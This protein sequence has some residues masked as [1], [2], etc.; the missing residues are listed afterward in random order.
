MTSQ[1]SYQF[2]RLATKPKAQLSYSFLPSNSTT[3]RQS[4]LLVFVNGLG[5][6]QVSW[7]GVIHKLRELRPQSYPA[8]LT[9]DRFGQGQTEDRDP[10][11]E[12]AEDPSHA[13]DC[14]AA[15]ADLRQLLKQI[16]ADNLGISDVDSL[17][18]V[19]VANSIG[20]A[21]AR[22]YAQE[23]KATV[24]GLVLLDSVLANS[25]FVSIIPDPDSP[26][27]DNSEPLP[28]GIT[29]DVLREARAVLR[30]TFHPNNGSREGLSRKNLKDLLPHADEPKLDGVKGKGA[31]VTVL[32]HDFEVF[33]NGSVA[34][35][36]PKAASI[37]YANPYWHRYNE[38]L[39]KLTDAGRSK[40]P[41]QVPGADH[42]IQ[43]DNPDF[44]A[45]E[46]SEVLDKVEAEIDG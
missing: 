18:I 14:M 22:L 29:P 20:C 2:L 34:I 7:A 3:A 4:P 46:V 37:H 9:Y 16:A 32:G 36:M 38:G 6:P 15:V 39:A 10:N 42:F 5:L 24:A 41:I 27:F 28:E 31:F 17:P 33:A 21:L 19:L 44:V 26:D 13:H 23:F 30:R 12:G 43:R 35:G 40:G 1:I 45:V 11:D 8:I 25:D